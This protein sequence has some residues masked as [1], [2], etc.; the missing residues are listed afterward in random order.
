[1]IA[2]RVRIQNHLI[3]CA[4]ILFAVAFPSTRAQD[5]LPDLVRRIKP[6][7]VAIETFDARGEKLSRGSGFFVDLDRVVTNRHVIEGA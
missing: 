4:I 6:S 3:V 2:H 5:S 1:M 7:A